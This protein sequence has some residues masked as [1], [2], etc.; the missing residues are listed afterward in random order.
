MGD[1]FAILLGMARGRRRALA[2]CAHVWVKMHVSI[3]VKHILITV[4]TILIY[5][6]IDVKI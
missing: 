2:A 5:G 1:H 6:L 3:D 4:V